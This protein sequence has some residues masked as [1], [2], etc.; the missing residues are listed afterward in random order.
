MKLFIIQPMRGQTDKEIYQMRRDAIHEAE[1][2]L[3]KVEALPLAIDKSNSLT[4]L[5][6]ELRQ[7]E[8]ADV[9][10]LTPDYMNE[11]TCRIEANAANEYGFD[12]IYMRR[13][14]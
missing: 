13:A 7:M 3:G 14:D 11:R 9:V 2:L 4:K 1:Q 12:C 8:Q 6:N 5:S 10:L